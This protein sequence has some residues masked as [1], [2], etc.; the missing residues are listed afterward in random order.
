MK[1]LIARTDEDIARCYPVMAELRPHLEEAQFVA[2][3]RSMAQENYRLVYLEDDTAIVAVAG[4]RIVTNLQFGRNLYIDDLSTAAHARS[5]GY[6]TVL[7]QWLE[8]QA[9]RCGCRTVHLDSGVQR[10]QAHKFYFR[11][12]YTIAAYHFLRDN[13]AD[14]AAASGT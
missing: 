6:G 13:D 5:K 9:G 2:R 12:G 10:A 3:V 11:H 1:T 4:Y 14:P 8:Q 7:L